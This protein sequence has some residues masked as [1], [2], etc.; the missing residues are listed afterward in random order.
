MRSWRSIGYIF[1]AGA[2]FILGKRDQVE[3]GTRVSKDVFL[4]DHHQAKGK[5]SSDQGMYYDDNF[6]ILTSE[7]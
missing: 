4:Q 7:I 1:L 3:M 2:H 5:Y 6:I